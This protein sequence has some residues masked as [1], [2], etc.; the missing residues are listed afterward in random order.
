MIGYTPGKKAYKLL[1]PETK[2]VFHSR[3]VVFDEKGVLPPNLQRG[4][5]EPKGKWEDMLHSV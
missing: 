5:D 1:D 3:H 2:K 4:G